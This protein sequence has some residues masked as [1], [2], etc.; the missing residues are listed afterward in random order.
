MTSPTSASGGTYPIQAS[1]TNSAATSSTA[2]TT[3]TYNVSSSSQPVT[4]TTD[5]PSYTVDAQVTIRATV[6][7]NGAPVQ[8]ARVVINVKRPDGSV[9]GGITPRTD[10]TGTATA[11][12]RPR[13][14]GTYQ[15]TAVADQNGV[16]L[17]SASTSFTAQ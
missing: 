3:A 6:R 5:R 12:F 4:V 16:I 1:A 13:Q 7:V 17:G 8:G 15:V 9:A 2:S 10:A 11:Y 14:A